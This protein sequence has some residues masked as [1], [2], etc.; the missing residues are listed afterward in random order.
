MYHGKNMVSVLV[1]PSIK[2]VIAKYFEVFIRDMTNKFLN[3]I[4]SR[5]SLG[6]KLVILV[7]FVVKSNIFAVIMVDSGCTDSR[8]TKIS[9]DVFD[10]FFRVGNSRLCI[11]I[12]AIGT[13]FVAVCFHLF[14][15]RAEVFLEFI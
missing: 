8:T 5:N 1:T 2:S 13:V 14:E 4:S 15:G 12:E 3:K 11:D 6:D 7:A 9:P 10:D